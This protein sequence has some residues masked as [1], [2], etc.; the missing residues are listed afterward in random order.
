[1]DR[2]KVE[3]GDYLLMTCVEEDKKCM[4][5]EV[6]RNMSVTFMEYFEYML[7]N[8]FGE[9]EEHLLKSLQLKKWCNYSDDEIIDSI[10]AKTNMERIKKKKQKNYYNANGKCAIDILKFIFTQDLYENLKLTP[11]AIKKNYYHILKYI[12]L[13][14]DQL[15]NEYENNIKNSNKYCSN[16]HRPIHTMALHNVLRQSAYGSFSFHSFADIEINASIAV[17][18]QIIELRVRRAF[19]ALALIDTNGNISPLNLSRIFN[20]LKKYNNIDYSVKLTSIER[21]YKWS[22]LYIH[23]GVG[24]YAWITYFL[25]RYLRPFS[26][27]E[28]K[29]DGSWSYDNGIS[30]SKETFKQIEQDIAALNSSSKVYKCKPECKIKQNIKE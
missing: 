27:G 30:L 11:T 14:I 20:V 28:R 15:I 3:Y 21:I 12:M 9:I 6:V 22:N 17:V 2:I 29:S 24:D 19:A 5:H 7:N 18:R 16:P 4:P 8:G 10:L 26:F 23:L 1:M 25:E 13:D